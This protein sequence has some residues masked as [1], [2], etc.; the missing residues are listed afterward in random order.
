MAFV[1][2]CS[3]MFAK[4]CLAIISAILAVP[5]FVF[6]EGTYIPLVKKSSGEAVISGISSA[7][8]RELLKSA[9]LG[10]ISSG[11]GA[12]DSAHLLLLNQILKES[13]LRIGDATFTY[14]T[15][16]K[17]K[18]AYEIN[19]LELI[20]PNTLPITAADKLNGIEQRMS[21]VPRFKA[22][23]SH[24][25][26]TGWG[27]WKPAIPAFIPGVQLEKKNGKWQVKH[28]PRGSFSIK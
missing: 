27:E 16:S 15:I 21:Y 25:P 28:S 18:V 14:R 1:V 26:K 8:H 6:G 3:G 22:Y 5:V 20:G 4:C 7:L 17:Q 10:T 23:R 24:D 19:R 13:F 11:N 12:T 2:I 9:G